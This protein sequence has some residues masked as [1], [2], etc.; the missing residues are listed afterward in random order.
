MNQKTN[1]LPDESTNRLA[2]EQ[3][4]I[5]QFDNYCCVRSPFQIE[6]FFLSFAFFTFFHSAG[7]AWAVCIMGECEN[8]A[9]M[10]LTIREIQHRLVQGCVC[11]AKCDKSEKTGFSLLACLLM[12]L[13][14]M[15]FGAL[16]GIQGFAAYKR[17]VSRF[18][19]I[20]VDPLWFPTQR[21]QDVSKTEVNNIK[22]KEENVNG[23]LSNS[24]TFVLEDYSLDPRLE[25]GGSEEG[26][27]ARNKVLGAWL[28]R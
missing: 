21:K 11:E 17:T 14:A 19:L 5:T 15:L 1:K 26:S 16:I 20:K 12:G 7:I 8:L 25:D 24:R 22:E 2:I 27:G 18:H 13:A 6:H 3:F 4:R 9:N 28:W 23:D 10:K